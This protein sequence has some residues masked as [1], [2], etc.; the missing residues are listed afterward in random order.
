[1]K[2]SCKYII[3]ALWAIIPAC[4]RETVLPVNDSLE[5]SEPVTVTVIMDSETR[6]TVDGSTGAFAFSE[7]DAIKIFDGSSIYTGTTTSTSTSAIFVMP[8]GF[9]GYGPGYAGFPA[10]S[11]LNITSGGVTF[12]LPSMYEYEEVGG[13]DANVASVPCPMVGTYNGG[14]IILRAVCSLLRFR[15]TN[16]EAGSLTFTFPTKVC[17]DMSSGVKT[18]TGMDEGIVTSKFTDHGYL[19]NSI[20]VMD[21]PDV[22]PGDY[23]WIT[24]PVPVGTVAG[25]VLVSNMPDN[26]VHTR[27]DAVPGTGAVLKRA[28]GS[29]F[30]VSLT[31]I[32]EPVFTGGSRGKFALAPGNLAAHIA[33]Y[34]APVATADQWRFFDGFQALGKYELASGGNYQMYYGDPNLAV[35]QWV[36]VFCW[37]GENST[38]KG[39]GLVRGGDYGNNA[40]DESLYAGCWSTRNNNENPATDGYIHISNG[41]SYN[42]RPMDNVEIQIVLGLYNSGEYKRTGSIVNGTEG[43]RYALATVQGLRGVLLFPDDGVEIWDSST[44]GTLRRVNSRSVY[45]YTDNVFDASNMFAMAKVGVAFWPATDSYYWTSTNYSK[46][47]GPSTLKIALEISTSVTN[48]NDNC[49]M[50]RQISPS[51]SVP[52]RLFRLIE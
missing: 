6:S 39:Q 47:W 23:I 18:P 9:N 17:G 2:L 29:V 7:G 28:Y 12:I 24:L 36:D 1:M 33:G 30:D 21:V 25:N 37:Q 32:P 20:T 45:S 35:G 11:V 5:S 48:T 50:T 34:S 44:M 43:C 31:D 16:V 10:S 49:L 26:D 46:Y 13:T 40:T 51:T 3:P 27:M 19:G 41:G 8:V 42:W 38:G 4:Q 15:V 22:A 52:V 14:P